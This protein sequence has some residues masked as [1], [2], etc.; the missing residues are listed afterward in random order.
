M[1][2]VLDPQEGTPVPTGWGAGWALA[3]QDTD[4][5]GGILCLCWGSDAVLMDTPAPETL[6]CA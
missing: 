1:P 5:R 2:T 4:G 3:G 6:E